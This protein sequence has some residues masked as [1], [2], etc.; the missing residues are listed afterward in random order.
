[1]TAHGARVVRLGGLPMAPVRSTGARALQA[2]WEFLHRGVIGASLLCFL[3]SLAG[4]FNLTVKESAPVSLLRASGISPRAPPALYQLWTDAGLPLKT[5]GS[6]GFMGHGGVLLPGVFLW[7]LALGLTW[8]ALGFLRW[9]IDR[10]YRALSLADVPQRSG[11]G[12]AIVTAVARLFVPAIVGVCLYLLASFLILYW[13]FPLS[14]LGL[15]IAVP[16]ELWAALRS[17]RKP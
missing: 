16:T 15:L 2:V 7:L 12:W 5:K 9:F 13:V 8:A 17:T 10:H 14:I 1:V 4:W 3:L 6:A 11:I